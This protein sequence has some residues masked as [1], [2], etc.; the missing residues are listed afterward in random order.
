[1]KMQPRKVKLKSLVGP[2]SRNKFGGPEEVSPAPPRCACA[3]YTNP[4]GK[5]TLPV[6]EETPYLEGKNAAKSAESL[7]IP[8]SGI[9]RSSVLAGH[10]HAVR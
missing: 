7:V 10:L 1:M 4:A 5:R 2:L 8:N 9:A 3:G 6:S